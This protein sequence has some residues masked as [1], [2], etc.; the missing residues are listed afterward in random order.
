MTP[1]IMDYPYRKTTFLLG[2]LKHKENDMKRMLGVLLC[3]VMVLAFIGCQKKA[4]TPAPA[5]PAAPTATVTTPQP[6]AQPE[7]VKAKPAVTQI[8]IATAAA[9]GAYYPVGVGLSEIFTKAI[10]GMSVSVEVT[11]GTVENPG[12]VDIGDCEIGIANSDMA[13][14]AMVGST[15]FTKT[16]ENI[17][18]FINGMAPGVVHYAVLESSGIKTID[19]LV[20]KRVAVGPQGNS[21][22]LFL[23]KVL[24]LKGYSWNDIIPS[25]LSFSEGMQAL[26]DGKVAMAI[27]SAGPPVSAVQELAA[28]GKKFNL[29]EFDDE[30][31]KKFLEAYPYYIAYD[32]PKATY[33]LDHDTHTVATQNMLMVN[34]KLDAD[35]VYQM[36]K[37]VFDN[38]S[39]LVAASPS[40]KTITLD[41]AP[42]TSIPLHEGAARYYKEMGVLK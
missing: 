38:F 42:S 40:A 19:D 31:R 26:A 1:N 7:P 33:G 24:K 13:Y 9:G 18:G 21:T 12:L 22:S 35:L 4:E 30:F 3:I 23:E 16:H 8:A 29:L 32:I 11:G 2:K 25:Y 17:R 20:G 6:A 34:A 28:T 5:T 36:T 14:F 27:A 37:A 39:M 41:I 15:P 10:P